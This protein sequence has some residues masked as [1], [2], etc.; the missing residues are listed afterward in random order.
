[1]EYHNEIELRA[2]LPK[3]RDAKLKGLKR[4]TRYDS[5]AAKMLQSLP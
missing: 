3:G 2:N 5:L 1:M 4:L